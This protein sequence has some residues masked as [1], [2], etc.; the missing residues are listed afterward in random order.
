VAAAGQEPGVDERLC[1]EIETALDDDP[2][3]VR[4]DISV[5]VDGGAVFLYGKVHSFFEKEHIGTLAEAC[6]GVE[7]VYNFIGYKRDW[8][9]LPDRV[10]RDNIR[11]QYFWAPYVNEDRIIVT[12]DD[13][14]VDLAGIVGS[15]KEKEVAELNAYKAGAKIVCNR[16]TVG[17]YLSDDDL[18]G[19]LLYFDPYPYRMDEGNPN[20]PLR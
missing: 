4:Y 3:A 15:Q 5:S 8:I 13:G 16:L 1:A 14:V 6:K 10:I 19:D 11:N 17:G 9:W 7:K 20:D 2:Y 18:L 12:V